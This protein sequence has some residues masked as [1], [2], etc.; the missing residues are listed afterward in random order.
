MNVVVGHHHSSFGV[1]YTASPLGP[2]F[3][4]DCGCLISDNHYA[5]AYNK[6]SLIRPLLGCV[7][8]KE[9]HPI[10]IPFK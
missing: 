5:F 3:G 6:Q 8:I 10:L 4:V 1:N 2:R 7:V 9:N